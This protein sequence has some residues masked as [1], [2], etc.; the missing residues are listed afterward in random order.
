MLIFQG[1]NLQTFGFR[2][3][4]RV[5]HQCV[6]HLLNIYIHNQKIIWYMHVL[7][8]W[9]GSSTD[10]FLQLFTSWG[11]RRW[12]DP[13]KTV[14][15]VLGILPKWQENTFSYIKEGCRLVKGGSNS[16]SSAMFYFD[17]FGYPKNH[18]TLLWRGLTLYRRLLGSPNHQL[19]DPMILRVCT[20]T[21][22]EFSHS[23]HA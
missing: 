21:K 22:M 20:F 1:V 3:H 13:F 4:C 12:S 23:T 19:W 6:E 8:L 2:S 18:W 16:T 9:E 10:L 7:V 14:V 5:A 17:I 15:F 11:Y